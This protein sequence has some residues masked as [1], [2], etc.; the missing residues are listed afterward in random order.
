MLLCT[1]VSCDS[2]KFNSCCTRTSSYPITTPITSCRFQRAS[3]HCVNAVVFTSEGR[4]FCSYP[5][6]PWV[7]IKVR[8]LRRNGTACTF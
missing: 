8:A 6:T 1:R 4:H 5:R 7:A 3:H 2:M